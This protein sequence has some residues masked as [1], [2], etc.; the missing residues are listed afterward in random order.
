MTKII[1]I[2]ILGFSISFFSKKQS[3]NLFSLNQD[4]SIEFKKDTI[5]YYRNQYKLFR[6]SQK[7][8]QSSFSSLKKNKNIDT[9][10]SKIFYEIHNQLEDFDS[11]LKKFEDSINQLVENYNINDPL[12]ETKSHLN[13]INSLNKK[14]ANNINRLNESI[15][16][17]HL[18]SQ[19]VNESTQNSK[20]K[21]ND[22]NNENPEKRV[23]NG[24]GQST[25]NKVD[26]NFFVVDFAEKEKI[27][28]FF[29][30]NKQGNI[31]GNI[32]NLKNDLKREGKR[33][34]FATNAGM[35]MRDG[36]P[37]GLFVTNGNEITEVDLKR[38]LRGEFLNFYIQPNG[39]FYI[40]DKNS[41]IVCTTDEYIK[42]KC[43]VN[44]ATQSGPML[45]SH[46]VINEN[47]NKESRNVNVRNGVG[48]LEDGRIIFIISN[49]PITFYDFSL[50]FKEK[51]KCKNALYLDG[52]ISKMYV[53]D[54][55]SDDELYGNLGPLIGL[56]IKEKK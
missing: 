14:I 34:L 19:T 12:E 36:Y 21:I 38:E 22:Y 46:G 26:Y 56:V 11:A 40:S 20:N 50:I 32:N 5:G 7:D 42:L 48:L 27:L 2:C 13:Y 49:E 24:F 29:L 51:F 1:F 37:Q 31:Y 6:S 17:K 9:D 4:K 23:K 41:P 43:K 55:T 54:K 44:F 45:I 28:S 8:L 52:A 10:D 53:Q 3:T 16:Q 47:F 25:Y 18:N 39:I 35:Y 33:L 15:S 30:T